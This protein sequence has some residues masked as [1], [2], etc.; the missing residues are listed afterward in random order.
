MAQSQGA[1]KSAMKEKSNYAQGKSGS[2]VKEVRGPV[3]HAL[4]GNPT[5]GGGI[6][7]ATKSN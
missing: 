2:K 4:P 7:R 6:N 1:V 3:G 5:K